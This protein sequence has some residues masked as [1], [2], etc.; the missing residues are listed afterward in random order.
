MKLAELEREEDVLE[1]Q[2]QA[3][4]RPERQKSGVFRH[5]MTVSHQLGPCCYLQ[6]NAHVRIEEGPSLTFDHNSCT[7]IHSFP[8]DAMPLFTPPPI[9]LIMRPTPR[10]APADG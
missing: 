9:T 8:A 2:H 5:G 7:V 3:E 4:V 6:W 1:A 10:F